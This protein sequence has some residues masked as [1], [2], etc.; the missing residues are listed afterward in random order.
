M[1]VT[2]KPSFVYILIALLLLSSCTVEEKEVLLFELM[3]KE[4][5]GIDFTNQLTY[6][7]QFNPYTFRNFYNGGG[8]AL[9]DINN[10]ELTDIF[11]AG[12]QVGNKLYLNKGNFEFEDITEIA[13]LAVENIWSTGVSMAD[14]NGD[15]LLDIYICKSGPLGGEQRHN[16]LFIN[17]GDLTFT[18]MSQE[19]GLFIEGEIRD[20]KKIRTQEGYKLAVIRNNDSLILLDK[21]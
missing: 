8:V 17:N 20:I 1:T 13:G 15:G 9:G 5:T 3:D 19:Y 2:S 6:T 21:N 14:V 16:E 4:D 7:E 11:F 10:D 18:E 12:N